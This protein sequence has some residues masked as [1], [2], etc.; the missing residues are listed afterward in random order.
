MVSALHLS[1][2]DDPAPRSIRTPLDLYDYV[3]F[4][5]SIWSAAA[6][7]IS[8]RMLGPAFVIVPI[9]TCAIYAILR[10]TAPPIL[11]SLYVIYC[12][13]IA[14]A[15]AMRLMPVSWQ[16]YFIPEAIIRQL[17]PTAAFLTVSWASM[18]YFLR[19]RTYEF[20]CSRSTLILILC[21]VAAPAT[22]VAQ[23][24]KYQGDGAEHSAL[25]LYGALINNILIAVFFLTGYAFLRRGAPRWFGISAIVIIAIATPFLQFKILTIAILAMLVGFPG[26][27][28]TRALIAAFVLVY[29]VELNHIPQVMM[30][31]SDSGIRLQFIADALRSL[32]D[33][34]GVGIGYGTESVR[35]VYHFPNLP[36][37]AFLPNTASMTSERLLEALSTGVHNSFVQA[38]MRTGIPGFCLLVSAF[39]AA[40]PAAVAPRGAR[41]HACVAFA[42]IFLA[43]FVN[44]ALES[45]VQVVG[46]G[47]I[48][49]YLLALR[50]MTN[51]ASIRSLSALS[52]GVPQKEAMSIVPSLTGSAYTRAG[53]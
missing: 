10:R 13:V 14:I 4:L 11:L 8:L 27:L 44:P 36:T 30:I 19:H 6:L 5:P 34:Y 33:T 49:G 45:P 25:A 37:F 43:C 2:E 32:S 15:S 29:A 17:V 41:S 50:R 21:L 35:W 26:R 31:S 38:L 3:L 12:A 48:Y 20:L 42:T 24:L 9:G 28:I 18:T 7:G 39:F 16:I 52:N 22:M 23:G 47:F 40:F 51:H 53:F 1:N 46:V